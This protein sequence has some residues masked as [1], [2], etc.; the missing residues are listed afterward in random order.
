MHVDEHT[1]SLDDSPVYYRVA[2]AVTGAPPLYLHGIPTSSDDWTEFLAR[3]GGLAPD[4]IGFGRSGKGEH[5]DFSLD[6]LTDFVEDFLAHLDVDEVQIVGHDWGAAVA[7]KFAHR[8]PE[9]VSKL[10]LCNAPA[11]VEGFA[12][13]RFVRWWQI[14]GVGEMLMGATTRTV[15][16][17]A[18]RQGCVEPAAW[19]KARIDAV[20]NQFDQGTQRAILRLVRSAQENMVGGDVSGQNGEERPGPA[21]TEERTAIEPAGASGASANGHAAAAQTTLIWGEKDPWYPPALADA[22]ATRLPGARVERVAD[23]GHWPWLDRP[24]VVERVAELLER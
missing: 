16:T 22:Y 7:L 19:P 8:H 4:L 6:G 24:E 10:V 2:E 9:R 18:L 5:L 11:L 23:A 21:G 14:R 15:L 13:P 17:R 20:W 12:W 3:T 1:I